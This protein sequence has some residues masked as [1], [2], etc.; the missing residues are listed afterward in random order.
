[1]NNNSDNII[2]YI[3]SHIGPK[4]TIPVLI[5]IEIPQNATTNIHR[6]NIVDPLNA[7][8]LTNELKIIKI[9]NEQLN[10]YSICRLYNSDY[11]IG[12]MVLQKKMNICFFLSKKRAIQEKKRAIQEKIW[13]E[14][15]IHYFEN[16]QKEHQYLRSKKGI[17]GVYNRWNEDG[18]LLYDAYYLNGQLHGECKEWNFINNSNNVI[19]T[20]HQLY[21]NGKII[22]YLNSD[23]AKNTIDKIYKIY[24]ERIFIEDEDDYEYNDV[25]YKYIINESLNTIEKL[26]NVTIKNNEVMYYNYLKKMDLIKILY[27]TTNTPNGKLY[28]NTNLNYK[29]EIINRID[30]FIEQIDKIDPQNQEW[31]LWLDNIKETFI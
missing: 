26:N 5:T 28:L 29:E 22:E 12:D 14:N 9:I 15:T 23:L 1:M 6:E 25:D 16:G 18:V 3:C 13:N 24:K 8:Y 27:D 7:R 19:L 2:G 31:N 17:Q 4:Y 10:E 11:K 30:E 21:S 20:N